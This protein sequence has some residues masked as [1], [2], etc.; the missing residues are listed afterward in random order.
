MVA[1]LYLRVTHNHNTFTVTYQSADSGSFG[2]AEVFYRVFGYFGSCFDGKL[3][4]ISIG[5]SQAFHIA[6]V[7]IQHHLVNMAGSDH[8]F[9]DDSADVKAFRHTYII[10][11]FYF[12]H[13]FAYSHTLCRQTGKDVCFRVAG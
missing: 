8:L 12:R 2:Q 6:D 5:E 4:Y 11:V 10:Y 3:R 7:G 13:C 9:I 1:G